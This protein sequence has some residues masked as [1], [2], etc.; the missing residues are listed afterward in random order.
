MLPVAYGGEH[1]SAVAHDERR[2]ERFLA[3]A[4][5]F[6]MIYAKRG[7]RERCLRCYEYNGF[8]CYRVHRSI[9]ETDWRE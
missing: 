2:F 1:W 6:T 8:C 4:D 9:A 5:K 3:A 7:T